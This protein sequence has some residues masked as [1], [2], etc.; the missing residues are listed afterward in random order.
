MKTALKNTGLY[1]FLTPVFFVL[2][3]YVENFGLLSIIDCLFLLLTYE[4]IAALLLLFVLLINKKHL[5]A[6][7]IS[8]YITCFYLFFG[9]IR[10]WLMGL[11]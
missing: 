3:G 7:F 5:K 9:A 10:D 11:N 4:G 1:L 6:V 2:H 8:F